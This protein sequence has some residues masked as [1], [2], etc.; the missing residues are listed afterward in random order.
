LYSPSI[1]IFPNARLRGFHLT[2]IDLVKTGTWLADAL[3]SC[4]LIDAD[5]RIDAAKRSSLFMF[6]WLEVSNITRWHFFSTSNIALMKINSG[7][8]AAHYL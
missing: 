1:P 5:S 3:V 8:G 2:A 7:F 4:A 6:W